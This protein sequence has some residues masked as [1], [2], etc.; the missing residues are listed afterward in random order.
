MLFESENLELQLHITLV[1]LLSS[2]FERLSNEFSTDF[3]RL[4]RMQVTSLLDE[5][6]DDSVVVSELDSAHG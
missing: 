4:F 5:I 1:S 3:L 6:F 2:F